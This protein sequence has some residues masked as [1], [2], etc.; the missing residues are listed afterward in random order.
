MAFVLSFA[1]TSF[2]GCASL[3]S[4]TSQDVSFDSVPSGAT[5][6][7]AGKSCTA[8][9]KMVLQKADVSSHVQQEGLQTQQLS[10]AKQFDGVAILNMLG[11]IGWVV[12][13]STGAVSKIEPTALTAT[14][15]N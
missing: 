12:D 2:G 7:V 13:L 9:C 11:L 14:L 6:Q 3:I 10:T 15:E 1:L 8:P 5:V 4:G